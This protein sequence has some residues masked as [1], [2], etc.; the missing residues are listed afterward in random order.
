MQTATRPRV[1]QGDGLGPFVRLFSSAADR[2][3]A[4]RH[5]YPRTVPS[6]LRRRTLEKALK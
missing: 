6:R 2:S 1:L 5:G 3:S 4:G